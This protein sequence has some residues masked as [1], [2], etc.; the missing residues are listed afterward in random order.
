ML[1]RSHYQ[2][3]PQSLEGLIRQF[4]QACGEGSQTSP[5]AE[6]LGRW[7]LSPFAGELRAARRI[8]IV[9]FGPLYAL[10][11][12][13]LDFEGEPLAEGRAIS[14]VPSATFVIREN[15]TGAPL[16][17][18][19]WMAV[20]DPAFDPASN[21]RLRRLPGAGV[22]A[23]AMK[24]VRADAVILPG[25]EASE[26]AVRRLLGSPWALVHLAAH[27]LLDQTAPT[28][29]AIVLAG[30]DRLTVADL[31]GLSL[32]VDL[33]VL[34][35]CDTG[36]GAMTMGGELIGLARALL[37]AGVRRCVVALWP[38]DDIPACVLMHE[39]HR[40]LAKDMASPA[41]ALALAQEAIRGMDE[42]ALLDRFRAL[43]GTPGVGQR[44]VRRGGQSMA[45][46]QRSARLL[47]L[48][49]EFEEREV[50]AKP[51]KLD[52]ALPRVWAPFVM[53]GC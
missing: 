15:S 16:A 37:T 45:A 27:G 32:Q 52:G 47:E 36:R 50:D 8:V 42:S 20:G 3:L 51:I 38:V 29:S 30:T 31:V 4:T 43:G 2:R 22:E 41:E 14:V 5:G 10:P 49:P 33:V 19:P 48:D 21:P 35:A 25:A 18:G 53:F 23:A 17:K 11:W 46:C 12:Q 39:F 34:S 26:A 7:L 6:L 44:S 40:L 1:F 24:L 13:A 9:P 28:M